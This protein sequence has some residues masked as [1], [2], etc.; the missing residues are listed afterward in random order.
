MCSLLGLGR[1]VELGSWN[2]EPRCLSSFLAL[3]G[4]GAQIP[5]FSMA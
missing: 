5:G 1:W 3:G 2:G 4:L